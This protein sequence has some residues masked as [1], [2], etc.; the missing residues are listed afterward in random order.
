V[1]SGCA[2]AISDAPEAWNGF[3]SA[4]LAAGS[5]YVIATLRSV[6]DVEAAQVIKT[7]YQQP[8]TLTPIHRLAA[9]QAQLAAAQRADAPSTR[10]WTSFSA[11]GNAGCEE[12]PIPASITSPE[13]R[14][15]PLSI[16]LFGL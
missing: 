2:T 8:A 12:D 1:L 10:A 13:P 14:S 3:P 9:A 6:G 7:Y 15:T 16:P 11:W 4:F 5:R